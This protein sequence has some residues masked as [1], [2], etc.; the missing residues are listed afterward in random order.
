VPVLD[1]ARGMLH[2]ASGHS[3]RPENW[4]QRTVDLARAIRSSWNASAPVARCG[5]VLACLEVREPAIRK[6]QR[7][8][9]I[10]DR[11]A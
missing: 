4:Q 9:G 7:F 11:L 1:Q 3:T 5:Y 8:A 6:H 2:R 10:C